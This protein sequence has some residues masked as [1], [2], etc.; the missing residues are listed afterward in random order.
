MPLLKIEG[1]KLLL[2]LWVDTSLKCH[3]TILD[4]R[5]VI[6][7]TGEKKNINSVTQ[8]HITILDYLTMIHTKKYINGATH[9]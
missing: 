1:K 9:A 8:L 2:V 6:H 5:T 7:T 3:F 4:Y